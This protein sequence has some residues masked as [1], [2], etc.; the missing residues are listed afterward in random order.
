MDAITM[1][2]SPA[3]VVEIGQLAI[4]RATVGVFGTLSTDPHEFTPVLPLKAGDVHGRPPSA[5][6]ILLFLDAIFLRSEG[7]PTL[8]RAVRPSMHARSL[9]VGTVPNSVALVRIGHFGRGVGR[10]VV[11]GARDALLRPRVPVVLKA[12]RRLALVAFFLCR[13]APSVLHVIAVQH[14]AAR[15]T[16]LGYRCTTFLFARIASPSSIAALG[17]VRRL[18][19]VTVIVARQLLVAFTGFGAPHNACVRVRIG[20]TR[21]SAMV[22]VFSAT[23]VVATCVPLVLAAT[24]FVVS[25]LRVDG[26]V[27]RSNVALFAIVSIDFGRGV[28]HAPAV[29]HALEQCVHVGNPR[30]R[31][32]VPLICAT[33]I[34][35]RVAPP[36]GITA[37][38]LV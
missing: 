20:G 35:A 2:H 3:R 30:V 13:F 19:T 31:A 22:D 6:M 9:V 28:G 15:I 1:A 18:D 23:L 33:I 37:L 29:V 5:D 32:V 8:S 11:V 27:Q 7:A 14:P 4:T 34:F 16:V 25:P 17:L 38:G 12:P 24:L 21:P 26:K 36:A 10:A